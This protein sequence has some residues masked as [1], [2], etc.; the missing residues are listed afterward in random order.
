MPG[1]NRVRGAFALIVLWVVLAGSLGVEV[2]LGAFLAGA[3][4]ARTG[5]PTGNSSRVTGRMGY[6]FLI[7]SSHHGRRRFD[8]TALCFTR[9]CGWWGVDTG[10][11][12]GD[13]LRHVL[14][15][16]FSWRE[17]IAARALLSYG[18]RLIIAARRSH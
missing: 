11:L 8:L 9:P 18:C 13:T 1:P 6:G 15:S 3:L 2:I 14:G 7:P 17:S 16:L 5:R 4:I 12:S 10:C